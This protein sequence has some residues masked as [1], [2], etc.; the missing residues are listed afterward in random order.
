MKAAI[1]DSQRCST[2]MDGQIL[3]SQKMAPCYAAKEFKNLI[4]DTSFNHI[5]RSPHYPQSNG[6]ADG[7]VQT[8]KNLI[9]K[10]HEEGNNYQKALMI[11]RNTPLDDN[12]LTTYC[13]QCSSC[14]IE[15]LDLIPVKIK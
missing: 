4:L 11:Y 14:S 2:N 7:Y 5:T 8:V 10:A 15:Q 6:L 12:L 1:Y 9:I 3:Y 13:H